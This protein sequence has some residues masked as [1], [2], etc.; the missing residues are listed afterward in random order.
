MD[1]ALNRLFLYATILLTGITAVGILYYLQDRKRRSRALPELGD[2]DRLAVLEQEITRL[3]DR[4]NA[5]Q[6]ERESLRDRMTRPE[7]PG[8]RP[9]TKD[10]SP[11]ST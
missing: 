5:L 10:Q 11:R 1:I 3:S 2:H 9:G 4:L 8:D 6:V 7:T